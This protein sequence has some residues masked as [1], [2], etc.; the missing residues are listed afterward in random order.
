MKFHPLLI[1]IPFA[2]IAVAH[3]D[4]REVETAMPAEIVTLS[5]PDEPGWGWRYYSNGTSISPESAYYYQTEMVKHE[6]NALPADCVLAIETM[7]LPGQYGWGWNYYSN[8][9]A[10]SPDG[11]YYYQ[12][13]PVAHFAI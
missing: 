13:Q 11:T 8:G 2:S 12:T 6:V 1:L 9:T 3:A 4:N 5:L 10:I 7:S